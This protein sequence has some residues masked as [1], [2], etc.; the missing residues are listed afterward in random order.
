MPTK[1]A[2]HESGAAAAAV[3]SEQLDGNDENDLPSGLQQVRFI[4]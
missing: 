1:R 3:S 2:R 4:T